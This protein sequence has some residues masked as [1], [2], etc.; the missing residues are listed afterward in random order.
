MKIVVNHLTRMERGYVCVAGINASTESH[1]RPVTPGRRL[2]I[3][4]ADVRGG[5]FGVR[6]VVE[7][8]EVRPCGAPP[9]VE[10]V[11]FQPAHAKSLGRLQK[12]AFWKL[13]HKSARSRLKD[14]FGDDLEAVGS[15]LA[16]LPGKGAG[17]LGCLLPSG[18]PLLWVNNFGKARLQVDDVDGRYDLSVTDLRLH[19]PEDSTPDFD[20]VNALQGQLHA[21][22]A[23][24][25]SMGLTKSW[26]KPGDSHARHWLQVNGIH[27][28]G[29]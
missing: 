18:R 21:G 7:L 1:V 12:A 11:E 26:T 13:L 20:A 17:S 5:P 4:I 16:T 29:E 24:I 3:A 22:A 23:C 25:L 28:K 15:N 19:C 9:L 2:S 14:I 6:N 10:D 27:I 8:G